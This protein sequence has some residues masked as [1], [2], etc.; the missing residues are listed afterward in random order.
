MQSDIIKVESISQLHVLNGYPPPNHPLIT[1]L[2]VA[3]A[4]TRKEHIGIRSCL[5]MYVIGL[6]DGNCGNYYGRNN[7]DFDNGVL[8]FYAPNQV[9]TVSRIHKKG[10]VKGWMIIFHPDLIRNT[11]LGKTIEQYQFFSYAVHEALHLSK[12]EEDTVT[13]CIHL[14][15]KEIEKRV[16][17]HSQTVI[18]STLELILNLS[19]RYYERQFNTRSARH[20]DL[21]SQFEYHLKDYYDAG[22]FRENGFPSL[23]YF[24]SRMHLSSSYLSD[25]LKKETGQNAKEQINNFAIEKA[26]TILLSSTDTISGIAYELGFNYPHYFSRLFKRKTGVTP[27]EYRQIDQ[28]NGG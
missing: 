25:L 28:K 4:E 17:N 2:D 20:S 6:K 23:E 16:D 3:Q 5:G 8:F 19:Q 13:D 15:R 7:Y 21:V 14:I 11:P 24:S 12:E 27:M 10:E 9:Q 1:V 26:K 18:S 22:Q